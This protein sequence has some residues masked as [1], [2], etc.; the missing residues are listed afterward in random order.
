MRYRI[1]VRD[2]TLANHY[3]EPADVLP[4]TG[5][6]GRESLPVGQAAALVSGLRSEW[7]RVGE[8]IDIWMVPA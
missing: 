5:I 2:Y 6:F 1:M 3:D 4:L 8:A 7:A